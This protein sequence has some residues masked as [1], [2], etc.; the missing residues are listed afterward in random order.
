[1]R[2]FLLERE[3][4]LP[5]PIAEVFAFFSRPENLR[6][7]TPPWLN[8]KVVEVPQDLR[9]GSLIRYRLRWHRLPMRLTTEISAWDPPCRFVDRELSGPCALWNHE[10][11]FVEEGERTLMRDRVIYALP[12]AWAGWIVHRATV[13]RD[14][15]RIFNFRAEKMRQL[16]PS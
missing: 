14:V 4:S 3:Q 2:T 15:E 9:A 8:F 16:L 5:R 1:M 13:R 11:S 6:E 10:H 7:I 12:F